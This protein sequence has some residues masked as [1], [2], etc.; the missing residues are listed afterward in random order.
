M[1]KF[2]TYVVSVQLEDKSVIAKLSLSLLFEEGDNIEQVI[3][4]ARLEIEREA[5]KQKDL[6]FLDNIKP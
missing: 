1:A 3:E 6:G 4:N 2:D 5:L